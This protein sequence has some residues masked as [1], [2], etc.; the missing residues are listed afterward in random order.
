MKKRFTKALS[1][2]LTVLMLVGIMA[3]GFP[4]SVSAASLPTLNQT[5]DNVINGLTYSLFVPEGSPAGTTVITAQQGSLYLE[6]SKNHVFWLKGFQMDNNTIIEIDLTNSP[7]GTN[8]ITVSLAHG[9]NDLGAED[10]MILNRIYW[11]NAYRDAWKSAKYDAAFRTH[12]TSSGTYF[13]P[14][15]PN[16]WGKSGETEHLTLSR[17]ENGVVSY[18]VT[19]SFGG[20]YT[21]SY[22]EGM[23]DIDA[24]KPY[25]SQVLYNE[26]S[27]GLVSRDNKPAK[28]QIDEIR[29]I[30]VGADDY[31]IVESFD[32]YNNTTVNNAEA[33]TTLDG[34][35][36]L[37]FKFDVTGDSI[38]VAH[39]ALA[40][41]K[42]G[43]E[44]YRKTVSSIWNAES[45]CYKCTVPVAA[46]EMK[47]EFTFSVVD[48]DGNAVNN[49]TFVL[50]VKD[51]ADAV[52][53]DASLSEWHDLMTAMLN[54]GN[55]AKNYF[56]TG[57]NE[58]VTDVTPDNL[59]NKGYAYGAGSDKS[60][61]ENSAM[62]A[63]L[64]L[65][66]ETTLN[67]R[68]KP[69]ATVT[70]ITVRKGVDELVADTD[71]TV[72][73]DGVYTLISIPN[74]AADQLDADYSVIVTAGDSSCTL[75]LSALSW[76]KSVLD[77]AGSD[78]KKVDVAKTLAAYASEAKK[79]QAVNP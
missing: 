31:T 10:Y 60:I 71:Y 44:I 4:L 66:N 51:Y 43:L 62:L 3:V 61:F 19:N 23:A 41:K 17:D 25:G 40:V 59:T 69:A 36:G 72:T 6:L 54:Y 73:Q 21:L 12:Y 75:T 56:V 8:D 9:I 37:N 57:S 79:K 26:G 20:D 18:R 39:S 15:Q 42:N 52:L 70:G 74:I 58:T 30:N 53:A 1:M 35:I 78:A 48:K 47:D 5:G 68:F 65:E 55:A 38:D 7:V 11:G 63:S 16:K 50:S 24:E 76:A 49:A 46:K 13:G 34:T 29:I 22:T 45:K 2:L 27:F 14:S 33:S 28:F 64:V 67:I 77:N 32:S